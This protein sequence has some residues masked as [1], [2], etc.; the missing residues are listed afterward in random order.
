[1]ATKELMG[2]RVDWRRQP[3]SFGREDLDGP[4][5][6]MPA[7]AQ[8]N[9]LIA[10]AHWS[11]DPTCAV[12]RDSSELIIPSPPRWIDRKIQFKIFCMVT[13]MLSVCAA[14]VEHCTVV[15]WC[16]WFERGK[17][18]SIRSLD[19]RLELVKFSKNTNRCTV[20]PTSWA[21]IQWSAASTSCQHSFC[22][23]MVWM[24]AAMTSSS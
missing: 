16:R 14:K 6:R 10:G 7:V 17:H 19:E 23:R 4:V 20:P 5:G 15:S 2:F 3:I 13:L 9:C 8:Q 18:V 24:A 12:F 21:G 11:R 22:W 1:M